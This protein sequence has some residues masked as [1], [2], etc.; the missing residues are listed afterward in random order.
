MTVQGQR[1]G[2]LLAVFFLTSVPR[3]YAA[4]FLPEPGSWQIAVRSGYSVSSR[5][6][7]MVPA[8]LHVGYTVFKGQWGFVPAGSLEVAVEPFASVI[9]YVVF[10][11]QRRGDLE[12][13]GLFP[14]L[15]YSF[16]VG[17]VISPYIEGGLGMLYTGLRGYNLGGHFAFTEVIGTGVTC[18]V[19]ENVAFSVGGRFRHVSNASLYKNNAGLNSYIAMLGISYFL[20][21]H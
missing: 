15:T 11:D 5:E 7:D 6:V 14:L 1:L 18:F 3:G 9:T 20:P 17:S 13:G 16:D 8:H 10:P 12:L 2:W 19:T 4:D 21:Q